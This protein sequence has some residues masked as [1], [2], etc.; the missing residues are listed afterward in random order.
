[1]LLTSSVYR[2]VNLKL[3]PDKQQA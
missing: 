3:N 2:E 1:M